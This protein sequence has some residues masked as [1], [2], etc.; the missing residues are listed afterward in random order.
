MHWY[1]PRAVQPE[2]PAC[3]RAGC[4]KAFTVALF[5]PHDD[6]GDYLVQPGFIIGGNIS[7]QYHAWPFAPRCFGRVAHGL[8]VTL[9][10]MFESGQYDA[11]CRID[12]VFQFNNRG[13]RV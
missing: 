10:E 11:I 6:F 9:V 12:M 4:D 13:N 8:D 3:F 2:M 5:N 1:A 7:Q